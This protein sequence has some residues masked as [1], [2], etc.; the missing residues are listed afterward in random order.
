MERESFKE[1][2]EAAI[3]ERKKLFVMKS[4][5]EELYPFFI[6]GGHHFCKTEQAECKRI[7][8]QPRDF[9]VKD[10]FDGNLCSYQF[11]IDFFL[12]SR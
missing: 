2:S 12:G 9:T 11:V 8:K 5:F 6:N 7:F 1:Y 10:L 4:C 3:V